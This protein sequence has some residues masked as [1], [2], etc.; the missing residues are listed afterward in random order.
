MDSLVFQKNEPL[1]LYLAIRNKGWKEVP[2]ADQAAQ[3]DVLNVRRF[4]LSKKRPCF[5][6]QSL[7][8]IKLLILKKLS[9]LGIFE[10]E[11]FTGFYKE[12]V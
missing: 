3:A 5:F 8:R 6:V 9:T 12:Y 7:S 10:N 11:K 1:N 4:S 2:E